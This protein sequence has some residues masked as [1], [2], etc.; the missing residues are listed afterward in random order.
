MQ[1]TLLTLR[2]NERPPPNI[3]N[4]CITM[5][6]H[7]NTYRS[8][9]AFTPEH[10]SNMKTTTDRL[11]HSLA[12]REHLLL[13]IQSEIDRYQGPH[14]EIHRIYAVLRELE[15]VK[16]RF[17]ERHYTRVKEE[18]LD[19]RAR[20]RMGMALARYNVKCLRGVLIEVKQRVRIQEVFV[21]SLRSSTLM[22]LCRLKSSR[23]RRCRKMRSVPLKQRIFVRLTTT[24]RTTETGRP[25]MW[26]HS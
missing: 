4:S 16:Q 21:T 25:K 1:S 6:I 18:L 11:N 17:S 14:A 15:R 13:N 19:H 3:H 10:Y 2:T 20:Q 23:S 26:S 9:E 7:Q 5:N 12:H 22:R 8:T 24:P